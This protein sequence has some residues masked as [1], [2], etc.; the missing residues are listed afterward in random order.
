MPETLFIDTNRLPRTRTPNGEY[1]DVL[2]ER[3]A[4]AKNVVAQLRWLRSGEQFRADAADR[5][6][7]LYVMEG[8]GTV[9]MDQGTQELSKGMGVYLGCSETATIEAVPGATVKM[10]HLVVPR[11][12]HEGR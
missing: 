10:L 7:L 6:Q 5:H 1:A 11:I 4:G 12:P 8:K 9:R 3:L 2:N